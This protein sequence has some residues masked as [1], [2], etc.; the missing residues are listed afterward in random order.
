[1]NCQHVTEADSLGNPAL[2]LKECIDVRVS[3]MEPVSA[4][5]AAVVRS[6]VMSAC[7][8]AGQE[9]CSV[10]VVGTAKTHVAQLSL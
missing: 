6:M 4:C 2:Q 10:E 3:I 8:A 7:R 9:E 1:M 5:Q